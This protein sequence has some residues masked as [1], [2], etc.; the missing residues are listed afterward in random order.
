M[1]GGRHFFPMARGE[2]F[3]LVFLLL[4]SAVCFLP[5]WRQLEVVGMALSGWGM[6]ALMVISPVLTLWVFRSGRRRG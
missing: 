5:V 1:A 6:A 4:F 2:A 3:A